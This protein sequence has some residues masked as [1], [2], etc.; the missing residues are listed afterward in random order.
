MERSMRKVQLTFLVSIIT[1]F[2]YIYTYVN[3]LDAIWIVFVAERILGFVYLDKID[4]LLEDINFDDRVDEENSKHNKR[5]FRFLISILVLII[6][7][8]IVFGYIIF[9]YIK[10][11]ALIIIGEMIDKIVS[12]IKEIKK[13]SK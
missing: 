7:V 9:N 4:K 6:I 8:M 13:D 5:V 10:L 1:M 3:N 12:N 11:F 2:L